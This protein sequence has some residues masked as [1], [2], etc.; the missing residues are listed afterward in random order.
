MCLENSDW[1]AGLHEQR[2]VI[3]KI[4]E[5]GD[6]GAIGFPTAGRASG[7]SIDDE[8]FGTLGDFFVEIVHQ[9]AHGG[10]LLPT[11]ACDL[12]A[13][14]RANGR[15]SL[16]F[17]FNGHRVML[18]LPILGRNSGGSQKLLPLRAR[19]FAKENPRSRLR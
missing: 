3:V 8:I 18:V 7:S 14:R 5:S 9:H 6:D 12:I 10:F 4:L 19:R 2:L 13:A 1:F 15:W 11:F 16:D 17:C